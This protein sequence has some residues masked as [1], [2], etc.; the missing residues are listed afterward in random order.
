MIVYSFFHEKGLSDVAIAA[1]LG[2]MWQESGCDPTKGQ[3]GGPG[4]GL[5]QWEEGGSRFSQLSNK[6]S[7]QGK[8]WRDI[9]I[10]LEFIW[11][12]AE[13]IFNEASGKTPFVYD[14]GETAWWPEKYTFMATSERVFGTLDDV[15]LATEIFE[16]IYCRASSPNMQNRVEHAKSLLTNDGSMT[17]AGNDVVLRAQ[18]QLG[19]PYV[20]GAVGPNSFDC[21]GLVS[22]ALTGQYLRICTTYSIVAQNGFIEINASEA[23]PGDIISN[24]EHCGI[25]IGDGKMIHAPQ[26][27]E[28]ITISSYSWMSN[29]SF[30]RY[31]G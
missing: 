4:R 26:E 2:N 8:T 16:R 15:E 25:Y 19:K 29:Y 24:S 6:A 13:A 20:W 14:N 5:L 18:S 1:I 22:Y 10:Q 31:I 23:V 7:A 30:Y 21:S 9:N 28:V 12:E 11:D 17:F 3:D 27:G